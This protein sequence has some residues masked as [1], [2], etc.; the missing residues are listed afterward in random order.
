MGREKTF[1]ENYMSPLQKPF[2]T[3]NRER[4]ERKKCKIRMDLVCVMP[5]PQKNS[6]RSVVNPPFC[7]GV[8]IWTQRRKQGLSSHI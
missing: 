1:L 2:T 4:T 6:V 3:E 5:N 7:S 8:T